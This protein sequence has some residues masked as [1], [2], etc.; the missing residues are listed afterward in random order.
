MG[1]QYRSGLY[2]FNDEQKQLFDASSRA[3][4]AALQRACKG[5]AIVRTEIVPASKYQQ[6]F[7][8]AEDSHQQYLAKPGARPYCSAQPRCVSLPSF[9]TWFPPDWSEEQLAKH[10]PKLSEGFWKVMSNP[11]R[12][13]N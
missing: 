11:R 9:K 8:Y 1:T 13:R 5:K 6:L 12:T 7:Y 4:Q 3:Y 10:A 2:Y